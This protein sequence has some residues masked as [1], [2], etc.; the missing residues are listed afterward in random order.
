[1]VTEDEVLEWFRKIEPNIRRETTRVSEC[2][3][4]LSVERYYFEKSSTASNWSSVKF[5]DET[6]TLFKDDET[7]E[8]CKTTTFQ[9]SI[10]S[11]IKRLKLDKLFKNDVKQEHGHWTGNDLKEY[12]CVEDQGS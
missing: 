3:L 10:V 1:M 5:G 6:F 12:S 11:R 9:K 7:L 2:R 8:E 4:L